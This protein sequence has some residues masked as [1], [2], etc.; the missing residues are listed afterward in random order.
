MSVIIRRK[1]LKKCLPKC[2]TGLITQKQKIAIIVKAGAKRS[3]FSLDNYCNDCK[4][5]KAGK[6]FKKHSYFEKNGRKVTFIVSRLAG[7]LQ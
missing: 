5:L 7:T 3:Y 4:I 6:Q 2:L 1:P